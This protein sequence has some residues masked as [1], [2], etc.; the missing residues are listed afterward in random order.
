MISADGFI[1]WTSGAILLTAIITS[2]FY[3]AR[4]HRQGGALPARADGLPTVRLRLLSGLVVWAAVLL[5]IAAPAVVPWIVVPLPNAIRLAG[6]ALAVAAWLVLWWTLASL[7]NNISPST[8]TRA[9]ATLVRHGPYRLVRHPLYSGG[10]MACLG[11]GLATESI[12]LLVAVVGLLWWVPR[13]VRNEE[14]N[15]VASYGDRYRDYQAN[16]PPLVPR[17]KAAKV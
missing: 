13:R 4:A 7:G 16:T 1:R 2:G 9:G 17:F 8:S 14:A 10:F 6:L 15:L 11:L 5:P 12:P 3:R